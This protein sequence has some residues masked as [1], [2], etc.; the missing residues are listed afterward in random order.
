MLERKEL[1]HYR[2]LRS[3]NAEIPSQ[4]SLPIIGNDPLSIRKSGGIIELGRNPKFFAFSSSA[5]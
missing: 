5:S 2:R 3:L 1:T 4:K